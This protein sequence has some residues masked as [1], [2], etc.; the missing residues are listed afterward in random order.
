MEFY[1]IGDEGKKFC[2]CVQ[3]SNGDV[4]LETKTSSISLFDLER[5]A[6]S[7]SVQRKNRGKRTEDY[8]CIMI[9]TSK[10]INDCYE[11]IML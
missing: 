5:K 9:E 1:I 7:V 8:S 4:M 11:N 6:L 2:K 10:D 3:D